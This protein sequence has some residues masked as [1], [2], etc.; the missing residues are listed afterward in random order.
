MRNDGATTAATVIAGLTTLI[1]EVDDD[2][3]AVLTLD[4]PPVNA[5]GQQLV[6]DL[7]RAAEALAADASVRVLILAAAGR[8]FCAGADL[9][10]RQSMDEDAVRV[11]VRKLSATFSKL[12]NLPVPTVAA[13]HG[14][15]AGGG[16]E[17]ALCCDFRVMESSGRIGLPETTLG[18]VPG[19]GG[20]QRLPRLTG[21]STAKKWIFSGRLFA[22]DEALADGVVDEVSGRDALLARAHAFVADMAQAAPLAIRAAKRAID[23]AGGL[24]LAD[25]LA[26][27]W[28]AYESI[29]STEDRLEALAAFREKRKPNFRGR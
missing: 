28:T 6:A 3:I 18:I 9:K 16:C 17:L 14:T 27:E 29:L 26:V 20:T 19:A 12:A 11:F 10:E 15:A 5:L 4:R 25:G 22:A 8:T 24:P 2:G 23:A 13:I 21:V 1:L 7:D